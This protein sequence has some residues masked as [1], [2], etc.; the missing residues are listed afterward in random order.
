MQSDLGLLREIC[1]VWGHC[2]GAAA[3][4]GIELSK[5]N[6]EV[7]FGVPA[8]TV[9]RATKRADGKTSGIDVVDG[10]VGKY[11][12]RR[13]D[14]EPRERDARRIGGIAEATHGQP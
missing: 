1:D 2:F 13:E 14:R 7:V 6:M 5:T 10:G 9:P 3:A 11:Q 12:E 4:A 8:N